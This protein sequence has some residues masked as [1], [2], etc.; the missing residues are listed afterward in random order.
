MIV[1]RGRE[2][3]NL[4]F[5][6]DSVRYIGVVCDA[7]RPPAKWPISVFPHKTLGKINSYLIDYLDVISTV[8]HGC[9][10]RNSLFLGI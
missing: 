3:Q 7:S 1:I 6:H 5:E 4:N 9:L 10:C 8:V 2:R